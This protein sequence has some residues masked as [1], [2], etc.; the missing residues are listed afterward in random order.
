MGDYIFKFNEI[1][2]GKYYFLFYYF[3]IEV[4]KLSN[5]D[6]KILIDDILLLTLEKMTPLGVKRMLYRKELYKLQKKYENG[7]I[8]EQK[9]SK[10][11]EKNLL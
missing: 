5:E 3:D 1:N 9:Y 2:L 6:F 11:V 8:S 7:V 4:L 10:Q